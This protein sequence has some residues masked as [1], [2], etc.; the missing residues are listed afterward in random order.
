M[1]DSYKTFGPR[2]FLS[3]YPHT[4]FYA[5]KNHL[6][7]QKHRSLSK[8]LIS[9]ALTFACAIASASA[10]A[11]S[12]TAKMKASALT[13]NDKLEVG[14]M[15]QT[16]VDKKGKPDKWGPKCKGNF[17]ACATWPDYGTVIYKCENGWM[18]RKEICMWTTSNGGQCV[19]NQRKNTYKKF[20]PFV[21]GNKV[22]CVQPDDAG[23][24]IKGT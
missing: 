19:K 12:T 22:V 10:A 8:M 4:K 1:V 7:K 5:S 13:W 24:K 18:K 15:G 17:Q 6:P 2:Y 11:V 23:T 14:M 20:Y 16:P 3:S 9:N 21:D